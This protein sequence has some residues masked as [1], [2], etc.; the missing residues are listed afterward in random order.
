MYYNPIERSLNNKISAANS[1][2]YFTYQK[3]INLTQSLQVPLNQVNLNYIHQQPLRQS[4]SYLPRQQQQQINSYIPTVSQPLLQLSA[5]TYTTNAQITKNLDQKN[6]T[7]VDEKIATSKNSQSS[8]NNNKNNNQNDLLSYRGRNQ[9]EKKNLTGQQKIDSILRNYNSLNSE[10]SK[11]TTYQ[12]QKKQDFKDIISNDTKQILQKWNSP[13]KFGVM[14]SQNIEFYQQLRQNKSL[15]NSSPINIVDP[16]FETISSLESSQQ[17]NQYQNQIDKIQQDNKDFIQILNQ[18]QENLKN[19]AQVD[20]KYTKTE[21]QESI[22]DIEQRVGIGYDVHRLVSGRKL[23]IGGVELKHSKGLDG[24]SDADVLVHSIIDSLLGACKYGDIGKLFPNTPQYKDVSS[25]KLLEIVRKMMEKDQIKIIN[26]DAVIIAQAPKMADYIVQMEQNI[27][28]TLKIESDRISVKATTE[29]K[30]GFTGNQQ[31]IASKAVSL[32]QKQ[33]NKSTNFQKSSL[34]LQNENHQSIATENQLQTVKR[35]L[36]FK[37]DSDQQ[38]L[39]NPK[40]KN[41]DK[42]G[43]INL[44]QIS[45]SKNLLQSQKGRIIFLVVSFILIQ[46]ILFIL[47][48]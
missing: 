48:V 13:N 6:Y 21:K 38:A 22:Q 45:N 15:Q 16:L 24:H 44:I 40:L 1:N 10:R 19:T 12:S 18:S 17:T 26:I 39:I 8:N 23:I 28:N 42:N 36:D 31:G 25:L 46:L 30:L 47:F 34:L 43:L 7:Q 20:F 11:N 32:I 33:F 2:P 5:Q 14:P 35:Q 37:S 3:N 9:K 4:F 41:K 27:S 29:D